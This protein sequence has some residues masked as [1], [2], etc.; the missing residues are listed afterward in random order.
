MDKRKRFVFVAT[1]VA[2]ALAIGGVVAGSAVTLTSDSKPRLPFNEPKGTPI[3]APAVLPTKPGDEWIVVP[4]ES[5]TDIQM[6]DVTEARLFLPGPGEAADCE[7]GDLDAPKAG[8]VIRT[9]LAEH[10]A[11]IARTSVWD[12]TL[13]GVTCRYPSDE[14]PGQLVLY[15]GIPYLGHSYIAPASCQN[16]GQG[17]ASTTPSPC[18]PPND[19]EPTFETARYSIVV[20]PDKVL[21]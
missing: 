11:E 14:F 16:S 3:P 18:V 1:V 10:R 20:S 21:K 6:I 15:I 19:L 9:W 2:I 17:A 8:G 4:P 12:Q 13:I 5:R 7:N